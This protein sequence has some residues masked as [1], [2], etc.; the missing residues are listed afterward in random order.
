MKFIT[1]GPSFWLPMENLLLA[2]HWKKSFRRP[3]TH[4]QWHNL[5]GARGRAASPGILNVK[6]G[7]PLAEILIS[8]NLLFFSWLLFSFLFGVF[9][10]YLASLD[11]HDI[12]GSLS[13]L[14]FFP[15]VGKWPP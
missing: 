7:P 6:P 3:S 11:I 4:S 10:F 13:F 8:I 1:S 9:L 5:R 2:P 14:N 12:P 15:C